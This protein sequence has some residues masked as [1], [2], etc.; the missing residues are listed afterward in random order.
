MF[1]IKSLLSVSHINPCI[2][3]KKF[4]YE[5]VWPYIKWG[6][7]G[8]SDNFPIMVARNNANRPSHAH[9]SRLEPYVL[10]AK[11]KEWCYVKAKNLRMGK[12]SP[13]DSFMNRA[14]ES[15]HA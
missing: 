13:I 12:G 5:L 4:V 6:K 3:E 1:T 10:L 9:G 7:K 2:R 14:R 8:D 15:S 11:A